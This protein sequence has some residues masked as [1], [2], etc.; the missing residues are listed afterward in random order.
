VITSANRLI[1]SGSSIAAGEI[2][3]LAEVRDRLRWVKANLAQRILRRGL[4]AGTR[5]IRDRAREA[6]PVESGALR[7]AIINQ[8][9]RRGANRQELIASV[10]IARRVYGFDAE[11]RRGV[12]GTYGRKR[13]TILSAAL[14][15]RQKGLNG[16]RVPRLYAHLVEFGTKPHRIKTYQH[17]GAKAQPF[18]RP[19]VDGDRAE[20][21]DAVVEKVREDLDREAR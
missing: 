20:I 5:V 11:G 15:G 1:T 9:N 12:A 10:R 3:G 7:A 2:R 19:A 14:G 4:L 21:L 17:P 6:V 13:G 16:F 8:T 18:L